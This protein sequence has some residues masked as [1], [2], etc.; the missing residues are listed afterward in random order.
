MIRTATGRAMMAR[1]K[2]AAARPRRRR[3][4][5]TTTAAIANGGTNSSSSFSN[6]HQQSSSSL[7]RFD[8]MTGTWV[9]FSAGRRNRPQQTESKTTTKLR[10]VDLPQTVTNCPF[11]TGNEH[12]TPQ[13]LL[14]RNGMRVVPNKYPA[15]A[16]L[17]ARADG[18][19]RCQH[20]QNHDH[21]HHPMS[22]L[23]NVGK[24]LGR[25]NGH[26]ICEPRLQNQ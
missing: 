16:P 23:F 19:Q 22:S 15:V 5:F 1:Q 9:V 13:E 10:L 25:Q 17:Q 6:T 21:Q 24:C 3:R 11:C 2:N 14:T 7:L 20:H 4:P 8:V 12:L 18:G 26:H